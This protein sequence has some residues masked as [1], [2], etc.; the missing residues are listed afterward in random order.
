MKEG[1][2]DL[3]GV[4]CCTKQYK[5]TDWFQPPT[6]I[7]WAPPEGFFGAPLLGNMFA[8]PARTTL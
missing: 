7:F 8:A 3:N 4:S 5:M 2:D 1:H 6:D